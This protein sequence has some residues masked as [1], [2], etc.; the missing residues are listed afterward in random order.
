MAL[1]SPFHP[2]V[3][4]LNRNIVI[5]GSVVLFHVAALWALQS[6]LLRRAVEIVVPVAIL[7]EIVAPPA[8]KAEQPPEP[9][10][11]A[12]PP[13][14]KQPAPRKV[15]STRP[16]AP[17]PLAVP[18]PVPA[19]EA[20]TGVEVQTR[21]APLTAAVEPA[22]APAA[23]ADKV[24]LPFIDAD[25]A[26]NEDVFRPPGISSRL[27]EYGTVVLRVTVGV[28]GMATQVQLAKS[29]G[30]PRLDNAALQGARRLKFKPAIRNGVPVEFS[31][32]FPV[33]YQPQ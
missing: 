17:Q 2:P 33:K 32:D 26:P 5:G 29:S 23:A 10:K 8:P 16:P 14:A 15:E 11:P 24:A 28:N 3:R 6:G 31:Y 18:S 7:S 19:P 21:P 25:Y 13:P 30:Y 9:V 27:G 20:P 4:Q 22:P 12:P 1:P